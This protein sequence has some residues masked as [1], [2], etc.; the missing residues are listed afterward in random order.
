MGRMI[1]ELPSGAEV[2]FL[3]SQTS[4]G[5]LATSWTLMLAAMM[6]PLIDAPLRHVRVRSLTRTRSR[7]MWSF[8]GGYLAVWV[9]AGV[10]LIASAVAIRAAVADP[11]VAFVLAAAGAVGWNASGWKRVA[12]NRCHA[13]P[14]LTGKRAAVTFGL[15]HGLSCLIGCAPLMIAA[16]LASTYPTFVMALAALW[17][18]AERLEPPRA[19]GTGPIWPRR[20]LRAAL[21]QLRLVFSLRRTVSP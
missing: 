14:P 10:P 3:L 20:A 7:A 9:A 15:R 19:L 2:R 4:P 8:V 12:L 5:V 13:R 6:V 17:I 16:L 1:L 21:H 11:A 18:W